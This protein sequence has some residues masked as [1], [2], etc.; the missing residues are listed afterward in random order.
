MKTLDEQE[1]SMVK[2]LITGIQTAFDKEEVTESDFT[3]K[4]DEKQK[5]L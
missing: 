3:I 5:R 1:K 4:C 2:A